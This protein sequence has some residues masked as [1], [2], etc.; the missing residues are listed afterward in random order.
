MAELTYLLTGIYDWA[1]NIKYRWCHNQYNNKTNEFE[2]ILVKIKA[3]P[4]LRANPL[5]YECFRAAFSAWNC[6]SQVQIEDVTDTNPNSAN[7][8][9]E[10]HDKTDDGTTVNGITHSF[11][12]LDQAVIPNVE[13]VR[14][15]LYHKPYPQNCLIYIHHSKIDIYKDYLDKQSNEQKAATIAHEIGHCFGLGH[16][17][18]K[19]IMN[20]ETFDDEKLTIPT[21]GPQPDDV[22]AIVNQYKGLTELTIGWDDKGWINY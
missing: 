7:I 11:N 2:K 16:D 22:E 17:G 3:G 12:P 20:P 14:N 6:T 21:P 5:Y 10:L 4:N 13:E 8:I 15:N 19:M 9:V 1:R 18:G